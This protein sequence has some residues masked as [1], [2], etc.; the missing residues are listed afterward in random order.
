M[1]H[2][3]ALDYLSR[4][5]ASVRQIQT[6]LGR[7]IDAWTR[8]AERAGLDEVTI[9]EAAGRARD[10]IAPVVDRLR[11]SGLLNDATFAAQ[12]ASR[13]NR[14]GKSRRAIT[15]DLA[16]KGVDAAIVREAVATDDASE[17]VAAVVLAKK[18]RLGPFAR[19]APTDRDEAAKAK[20]R[21]LGALARAGYGFGIADRVLRMDRET[22]EGLLH[23]AAP[24]GW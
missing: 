20:Q 8:R 2:E 22:A 17:L 10:R 12:R 16:T 9:A 21:A 18:K 13:L 23:E 15:F 14:A 24:P 7:R 1:L 19:E 6:V 11:G 4:R 3:A 5:S